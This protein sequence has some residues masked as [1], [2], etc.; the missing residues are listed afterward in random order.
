[1]AKLSE[2][3]ANVVD[4]EHSRVSGALRLGEAEVALELE[5][6]GEDH[7]TLVIQALQTAGYTV[8]A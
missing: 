6:R 7:C 1:L 5:T 2:L 3:G 8:L 4:V